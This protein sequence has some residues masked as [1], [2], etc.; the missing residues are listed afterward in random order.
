MRP[1]LINIMII[2]DDKDLPE[3]IK[4]VLLK[5][6]YQASVY[7]DAESAIAD[8][9][10]QKPDLILMDVM[11][12]GLNGA[13]AIKEIRKDPVNK[14]IPVIF[15]TGLVSGR[16][17]DFKEASIHVDGLKFQTLGKPFETRELLALVKSM[18]E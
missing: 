13:E 6:G 11:L 8:V 14:N 5:E 16:D 2:D 7:H 12:P 10:T 1:S 15:L 18:L 3:I 9:K 4:A 17:G